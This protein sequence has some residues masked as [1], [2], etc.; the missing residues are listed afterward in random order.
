MNNKEFANLLATAVEN[1]KL[2]A[3]KTVSNFIQE[4]GGKAKGQFSDPDGKYTPEIIKLVTT[5]RQKRMKVNDAQ[6][7]SIFNEV[8]ETAPVE[9]KQ[10]KTAGTGY[11]AQEW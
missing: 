7:N 9:K 4:H 10:V 8:V 2:S 5:I 11:R 6:L 1:K 3:S